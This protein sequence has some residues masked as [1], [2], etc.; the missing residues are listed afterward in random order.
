[1]TSAKIKVGI[2]GGSGLDNPDLLT[3][4]KS[5]DLDTPFGQPSS[6]INTGKIGE[7]EV[8]IIARHGKNHS[9]MPGKVPYQANVWALKQVGCSHILATTA[10]GSLQ[11]NFRPGDLVFIDQFID[12]TKHRNP[13]FYQ[14][15]VIHTPMADP[16]CY[17]LRQRLTATAKELKLPHH[18]Q[19]TIV[20]IEGPRFSTRAESKMFR[21]WQADVINMSTVP[22]VTLAR[23]IGI[24]YQ[25]IAMVTDYDC[26][27]E[28]EAPVTW[29]MVMEQM[30]K[31][32]GNIKKLLLAV[33]PKIDFYACD[34]KKTTADMAEYE[35][36]KPVQ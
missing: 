5:I 1:M 24:C 11:K 20:T 18:S 14:D 27:K 4:Q 26:W 35:T 19:G 6:S 36:K 34:C 33:L 7:V 9:L 16:F 8:A 25:S 13:T 15:H 10:C 29:E 30:N 28:K 3:R 21:S 31:N 17:N 22:E 23:E 32:I 2:I 12:F